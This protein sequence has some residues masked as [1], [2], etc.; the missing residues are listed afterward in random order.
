MGNHTAVTVSGMSGQFEL[1]VFKPVSIRNLLHSDRILS[2]ATTSFEEN[3]V[4]G[5]EADEKRMVSLLN[6]SLMLATSLNPIIGYDMA[7]KVAKNAH[8]HAE[9]ERS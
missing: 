3:L 9:R 4:A 5:V 2:D 1:G 6:E 7:S 8:N